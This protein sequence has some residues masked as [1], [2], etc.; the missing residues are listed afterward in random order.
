VD[1]P[2]EEQKNLPSYQVQVQSFEQQQ[3][4]QQQQDG[5]GGSGG[6]GGGGGGRLL[7]PPNTPLS[8]GEGGEGEVTVPQQPQQ[9][10]A[11]Q[12]QPLD[13]ELQRTLACL[14]GGEEASYAQRVDFLLLLLRQLQLMPMLAHPSLQT[15]FLSAMHERYVKSL[16]YML[17]V[18]VVSLPVPTT[19]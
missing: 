6:G 15:S 3:Q 9:R 14:V 19:L 8:R 1:S 4:Q 11:R 7:T 18:L 17:V 2:E 16:L 13:E 10:Q 12:A 5:G